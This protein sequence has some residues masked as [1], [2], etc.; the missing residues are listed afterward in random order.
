MSRDAA[1]TA[2][3][4]HLADEVAGLWGAVGGL[5]TRRSHVWHAA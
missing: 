2:R 1:Q 4:G 3:T 5:V